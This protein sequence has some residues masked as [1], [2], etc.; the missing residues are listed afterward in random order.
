VVAN[1]SDVLSVGPK[2]DVRLLWSCKSL[3]LLLLLLLVLL[4]ELLGS[5][6]VV[7]VGDDALMGIKEEVW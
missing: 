4:V 3:L 2:V 7:E 6:L 5:E 1:A